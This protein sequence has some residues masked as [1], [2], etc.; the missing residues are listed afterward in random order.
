MGHVGSRSSFLLAI[1]V[2]MLC[3][4]AGVSR[5]QAPA[6]RASAQGRPPALADSPPA[7]PPPRLVARA[8][9][10]IPIDKVRLPSGFAIELWATG[11]A[12][13]RSMTVGSKGTVFVGTRLVGRVYAV[14]D[15]G[16]HREVKTI[17]NGLHRPNGV[18]F[19]DGALYV[20]ELS[21]V[22][23][24]DTI[25][26]R[27]DDP[28]TPAVV[29]RDLPRD[30]PHG[31]KFIAFGP[32]GWLYVPVGAPCN[33]CNPPAT[34]AQI[35]RMRPDGSEAEVYARGVRNTVGFDWDPV[36][37]QLW[38]TDNGRDWLGDDLPSDE[39]NHATAAGQHFGYPFCHQG[40][41]PDPEFG[42]LG[43]CA[44]AAPPVVKLGAHVAALG[45][46]FYTGSMFPAGYRNRVIIAEHGSWN[47]TRKVGYRLV[48]VDLSN[49][50][51]TSEV[52][53]DGWLQGE[54]FWGRPVDV[55]VMPDGALL[56]SDD[57]VGALYRITYTR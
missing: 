38:F 27:L 5:A 33:I 47:R 29:Y 43:S 54:S 26:D 37:K 53:A 1:L 35:R 8:A 45:M 30:E 2:I 44:D 48:S 31:W 32:D 13:A 39:L 49:G 23:R 42:T 40:D 14:V 19:R 16:D 21:R 9:K 28:P 4:V 20:A 50:R 10:D 3:T 34:H 11:L 15:K 7:P 18:A 52:L 24:F 12:N 41:V 17:A 22:L 51:P 25:E 6:P 46:R 55:Q 57:E 36:T 56:V